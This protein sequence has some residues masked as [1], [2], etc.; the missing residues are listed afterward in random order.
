MAECN[1]TATTT[2]I[3][4]VRRLAAL[5]LTLCVVTPTLPARSAGADET[6]AEQAARE[7]SAARDRANAAADA[8]F[9]AEGELTQLAADG[10]RLEGEIAVLRAQVADLEVQVRQVAVN[11]F[12]R[13]AGEGSPLLVGF[14]SPQEEMQIRALTE[15]IEDTSVARF[16]DYDAL[17]N[18]LDEATNA[19]RIQQQR[20]KEQQEKLANLRESA[21]SEV[22]R[23]KEV[24]KQRLKDEA[25]RKALE[26]Q[27][28]RQAEQAQKAAAQ[29]TT[30]RS[31]SGSAASG[32]TTGGRAGSVQRN[33][34]GVDWLCP[35]GDANVGFGDTW[36]APRSG[37][38]VH[39]GTDVISARGTPLLAVVDGLAK[40]KVNEL[41]GNTVGLLGDDGNY[42]YYAHL[43]SWGTLGRVTKGTVVG[44]VGITGNA[45]T[46]H[47]HFEIH[48]GNG[49]PVNP[50]LTLMAHCP[51]PADAVPAA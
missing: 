12:T 29:P 38:R 36:L 23:L 7:I 16:D 35:T 20:T 1:Q 18:D 46:Y 5:A 49:D 33:W 41:G 2:R 42:Y 47:L 50:Y 10:V 15:V 6:A 4:H 37:G 43:E 51:A 8:Y 24:E 44:Y 40:P 14:D 17:N 31:A 28:R 32:G 21:E 26:E 34:A 48:P 45:S 22:E 25:V 27:Q 39:Y 9:Q 19:L 11:R 3:R 30:S 13:G